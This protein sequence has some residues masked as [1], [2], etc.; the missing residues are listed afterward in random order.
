GC[1]LPCRVG[2]NRL[3]GHSEPPPPPGGAERPR[4]APRVAAQGPSQGGAG[5]LERHLI[6][7]DWRKDCRSM[8]VIESTP[9]MVREVYAKTRANLDVVRSRLNRPLT[10]A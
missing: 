8:P 6:A 1:S 3:F 2:G 5:G 4:F 9:E 7:T 10:M